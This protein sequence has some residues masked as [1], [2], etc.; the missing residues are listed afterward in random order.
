MI[1]SSSHGMVELLSPVESRPSTVVVKASD[2][3]FYRVESPHL[4]GNYLS[5]ARWSGASRSSQGACALPLRA[6]GG[7]SNGL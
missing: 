1:C 4:I 3:L 6:R 5:T 7:P 2:G